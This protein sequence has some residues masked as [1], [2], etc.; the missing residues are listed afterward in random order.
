MLLIVDPFYEKDHTIWEVLE[1][2]MIRDTV[3]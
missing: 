3:G 1:I 2:K